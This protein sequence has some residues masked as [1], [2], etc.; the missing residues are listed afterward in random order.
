MVIKGNVI[1]ADSGKALHKIGTE[2]PTTITR[3]ALAPYAKAE[4]WED[5]D[6]G[7]LPSHDEATEEEKDAALRRFGVEM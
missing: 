4:D 5:C 3:V 2:T 1:L 7:L 6:Y